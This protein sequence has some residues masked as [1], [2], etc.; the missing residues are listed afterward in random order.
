MKALLAVMAGVLVAAS[1]RAETPSFNDWVQAESRISTERMLRNIAPPGAA[2]G[3]VVA[4]PSRQAPNY[5]F[6]WT[7][8]SSLVMR[9]VAELFA[10][11][12]G[13]EKAALL[14][15]LQDFV[16]L[17]LRQ[18][19]NPGAMGLGE[20]RY[21]V[22][23]SADTIPWARP[24]YDGPPLRAL[25]L[26]RFLSLLDK[27]DL[28]IQTLRVVRTDLAYVMDT[29]R[30]P[31]FDLWEELRG[32]HFYTQGVQYAAMRAGAALFRAEGDAA[33]ANRLEAEA[34]GA[35]PELEK[36][37]DAP[38]GYI[39]VSRNLEGRPDA[40]HY[41]EANLDTA[42]VLAALHSHADEGI[43]SAPSDR[44]LATAHA[45]ETSF[46]AA[47]RLNQGAA[48]AV[49]IGRFTDDVYYGGNPWYLTTAAFAELHYE[50]ARAVTERGITVTRNNWAFLSSA[51]PSKERLKIGEHVAGSSELGQALAKALMLKGDGFLGLIRKY[52]GSQGE[53]AEQF[54][55]DAGVPASALD[56][57]WSYASFL[58][59][60]RARSALTAPRSSSSRNSRNSSL[61]YFR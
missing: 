24:Q 6:H 25:T 13:A 50:V 31:C 45:L 59:A 48:G 27:S 16:A 2:P 26:I 15:R 49:A 47:Y 30:L 35:L 53:L 17:A 41:K 12:Q 1:A 52:A 19:S 34:R 5:Y 37:W 23:G 33:F 42:V 8:D 28:R 3:I 9:E 11:A 21:N 56:L 18:Q 46:A 7:R 22:D 20:P 51:L 14:S 40:P 43:L 60:A 57:T 38:R 44:L 10:G 29:W 36:Y 61:K 4:S 32:L 55:R 39:G 54:D 58:S